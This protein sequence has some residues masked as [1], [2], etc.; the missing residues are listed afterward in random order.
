M[1][2]INIAIP[3]SAYEGPIGEETHRLNG[4][5][6]ESVTRDAAGIVITLVDHEAPSGYRT[7]RVLRSSMINVQIQT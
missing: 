3:A 1:R 4:R 2:T 7:I 6:V 5:Q